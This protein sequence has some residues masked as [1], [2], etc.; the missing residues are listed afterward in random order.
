[1]WNVNNL[2]NQTIKDKIQN[3][4]SPLKHVSR[5]LKS[6]PSRIFDELEVLN[7]YNHPKYS[8]TYFLVTEAMI[9]II[10]KEDLIQYIKEIVANLN[11]L[12]NKSGEIPFFSSGK[13]S[14]SFKRR[15]SFS[16]NKSYKNKNAV[17]DFSIFNDI[18]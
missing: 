10:D 17:D 1:M 16:D 3:S 4:R 13:G 9:N 5:K 15:F 7:F 11:S 2:E 6:A 18:S 8:Y 14:K 12:I